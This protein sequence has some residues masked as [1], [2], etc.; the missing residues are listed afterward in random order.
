MARRRFV[1]LT[2][3]GLA[4]LASLITITLV[5]LSR[6]ASA[7]PPAGTDT[8]GVNAE[9]SIT[10]RLGSEMISFTGTVTIDREAPHVESGVEVED[11]AIT[12][13]DLDGLSATGFV[14]ISQSPT[15]PSTGELRSQQPGEQFPASS[16]FDVFVDAAIPASGSNSSPIVHN[17]D[18][19]HLVPLS[20]GSETELDAWP[21]FGVKYGADYGTDPDSC[22]HMLRNVPDPRSTDAWLPAQICVTNVTLTLGPPPTPTPTF[23]PCPGTC[24]PTAT[25]TPGPVT[26]TRTPRPTNTPT[27]TPTPFGPEN[28]TYSVAK[29]DPSGLHPA[30]LLQ[31]DIGGPPPPVNVSGND[32]F[33]DAFQIPALPFASLQ[34]TAG[35]TTETGEPLN[36]STPPDGECISFEPHAKG[37]TAWYRFTAPSSGQ[38]HLDTGGATFDTVLAAYTGSAVNS[39][40]P[41]V[42]NDDRGGDFQSAMDLNV[43]GGTVYYVQAGGFDADQGT[44]RLNVGSVGG[45]GAGSSGV[46]VA[47]TCSALGLS[48]DG[49]DSGADGDQDD[50][51]ALSY[52]ADTQSDE[53]PV[54]FSVAPGSLGVAASGVAAQAACSPPEPQ[55]DEFTSARN[56]TNSIVLDGDGQGSGCPGGFGLGLTER[57]TSDNLDALD[58]HPPLFVDTDT[59]GLLDN[60]IYFSLAPGSPSLVP[61]GFSPADI[62]WTIGFSPG[63]YASAVQLGLQP[64]DDVDGLCLI[65]VGTEQARYDPAV[66]KILFSLKAGSPTLAAL[67]AS[68]ADVLAPGASIRYHA[69]E[70]GLRAGDDLD[71]MKCFQTSGSRTVKV[72]VGDIYFCDPAFSSGAVCE[73]KVNVGD[74]VAWN[75]VDT[76]PHNV[77]ECGPTCPPSPGRTPVFESKVM[78]GVDGGHF[79]FT[80]NTAGTYL[81]YC[82]IHGTAQMGRIVVNGAGGGTPTNTPSG[83]TA[84]RTP[85]PTPPGLVGDANKDGRINAIDAALVLQHA[86]GLLPTINQRADANLNGTVNAI[87]AALI[88]QYVA[89]LLTRL[90]P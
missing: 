48:G 2:S 87:D 79:E 28:P 66:D 72:T 5:T 57:P 40:T 61:G 60:P 30:A 85:T 35:F 22:I 8:F 49:C 62:L 1:P 43:T 9:V 70:L 46:L 21:P 26:P 58:G 90:P 71:A 29:G 88:L 3:L 36:P 25:S 19:L 45:A 56:G 74:T 86:A 10:S 33:A 11:M 39:L 77:A 32:D 55:A 69:A 53:D 78:S 47:V 51:D 4:L 15:R 27:I 64:G 73:T 37:A 13:L 14:G 31:L 24:P 82:E 6:S 23:T 42:C 89:G 75:W 34:S 80:F 20:G 38:I 54:A 59:D 7:L 68:A 52:G 76:A 50:V 17:E 65:D 81:Y 63:L 41:L 67:H 18:A 84:T 44:L 16:F 12:T 83:P